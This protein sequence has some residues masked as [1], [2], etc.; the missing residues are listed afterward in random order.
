MKKIYN[1]F[2]FK[3]STTKIAIFFLVIILYQFGM[4]LNVISRHI[5]YN[6]YDL[7]IENFGYLSLFYCISLFY[8]IIVYNVCENTNFYKYLF[9]K[10]KNKYQ[11]YNAN[12]LFIFIFAVIVVAFI[13]LV[14]ILQCLNNISFKNIWSPYFFNT[15]TGSINLVYVAENVKIITAKLTPLSYVMY[16]NL[17]VILYLFFL[18]M[19]FFVSNIFFNNRAISFILVIILNFMSMFLDSINGIWSKISFTYNIFFISSSLN[20]LNNNSFIILRI[21]YWIILIFIMYYIGKILTKKIDYSF[22]N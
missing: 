19:V 2:L 7:L 12:V 6:L 14:C 4:F 5:Q 13:N 17:F 8:L 11:V 20:E 16:S 15:M 21:F 3:I 1:Y 18:S 9:L 22:G 10:F